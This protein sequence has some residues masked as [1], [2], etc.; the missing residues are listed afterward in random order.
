MHFLFLGNRPGEAEV[1]W[2]TYNESVTAPFITFGG[3]QTDIPQ[4]LAGCYVGCVPT[5]GWDSFPL[6]PLEMQACGIPVIVSDCQG[7]PDSV[8]D[9]VTGFVVP[10]GDIEALAAALQRVVDDRALHDKM[11]AAAVQR[12]RSSFTQGQQVDA[13]ADL[14]AR[15]AGWPPL[16]AHNA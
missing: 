14:I 10:A 11:S 6:S 2:G 1:F 15:V 12:I 16:S 5:T 13:L 8:V 4:L 3:Y 9:G 7:L